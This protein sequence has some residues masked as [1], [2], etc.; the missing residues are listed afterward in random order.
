MKNDNLS[1]TL[2]FRLKKKMEKEPFSHFSTF[3]IKSKKRMDEW[4]TDFFLNLCM[5]LFIYS[6]MNK[7][8]FILIFRVC[9]FLHRSNSVLHNRIMSYFIHIILHVKVSIQFTKLFFFSKD[10]NFILLKFIFVLHF[11]LEYL[12]L[13]GQWYSAVNYFW[14]VS[15]AHVKSVM[16][17]YK[18]Y[19]VYKIITRWQYSTLLGSLIMLLLINL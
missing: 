17:I 13:I 5:Y 1:G 6:K 9:P 8:T 3:N 19:I 4:N 14:M 2:V 16:L 11:S 12:I 15:F 10:Q 7:Q 18:I